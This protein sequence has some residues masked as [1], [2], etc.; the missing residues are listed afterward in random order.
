MSRVFINPVSVSQLRPGSESQEGYQKPFDPHR[1]PEAEKQ[2]APVNTRTFLY[3]ADRTKDPKGEGIVVE[4][5]GATDPERIADFASKLAEKQKLGWSPERQQH[6]THP[7]SN[8]THR[9]ERQQI[10]AESGD[11]KAAEALKV[12]AERTAAPV[13]SEELKIT[14]ELQAER[15]LRLEAELEAARSKGSRKG[16]DAE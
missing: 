1:M 10:L 8:D 15:I 6:G 13:S 12:K 16:K 11:E 9:V 3:H 14:A 4:G 2:R 7:H 5:V